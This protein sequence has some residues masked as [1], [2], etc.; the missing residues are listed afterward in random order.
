MCIRDRTPSAQYKYIR[1]IAYA[2][3][4][5]LHQINEIEYFGTI[6][7]LDR[8]FLSA[9]NPS[10]SKLTFRATDVAASVVDPASAKLTV[11]NAAVSL[12]NVKSGAS[13]DFTGT[14]A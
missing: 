1:Y 10:F 4:G 2:T 11:D 14:Y 6:G 7:G 9:I 12:T 8:F 5:T 13:T 3:P